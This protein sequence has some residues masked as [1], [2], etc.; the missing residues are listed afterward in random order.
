MTQVTCFPLQTHKET[1]VPHI[2][3]QQDLNI[4]LTQKHKKPKVRQR[5]VLVSYTKRQKA[6]SKT[7][8]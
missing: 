4:L 2:L 3:E 5:A 1:T 6:V 8:T 7:F